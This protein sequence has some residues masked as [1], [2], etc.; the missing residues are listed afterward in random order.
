MHLKLTL[1]MFWPSLE[2]EQFNWAREMARPLKTR[3][4]AKELISQLFELIY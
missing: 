3:L 1:S 2:V 4:T